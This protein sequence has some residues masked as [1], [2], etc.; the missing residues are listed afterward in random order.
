MKNLL[1]ILVTYSIMTVLVGVDYNTLDY[2]HQM[3][4]LRYDDIGP[5]TLIFKKRD[6]RN[7]EKIWKAIE[8]ILNER[9]VYTISLKGEK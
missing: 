7:K 9:N 1:T 5:D 2:D 8:Q 3:I 4:T 6:M